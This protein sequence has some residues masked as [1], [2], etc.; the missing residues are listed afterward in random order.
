MS[1]AVPPEVRADVRGVREAYLRRLWVRLHGRELRHDT[2][3]FDQVWDVLDG[4]LRSVILDQ[5]DRLR[6][7]LERE[8]VA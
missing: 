8:A 2:V 7:V 1:T 3:T 5:R 6:S 4:V